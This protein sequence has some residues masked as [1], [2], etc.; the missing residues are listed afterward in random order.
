MARPT[1]T[2]KLG[3]DDKEQIKEKVDRILDR[4]RQVTVSLRV[5]A[6]LKTRLEARAAANHRNLSQEA[7]RA[8]ERSFDPVALFAD[9]LAA[10]D[11]LPPIIAGRGYLEQ[12]ARRV[13]GRYA[14]KPGILMMETLALIS[15]GPIEKRSDLPL[16]MRRTEFTLIREAVRAIEREC[17]IIEDEE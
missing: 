15:E 10:I 6:E 8:L 14:A 16:I 1:K 3:A 13:Y 2:P 9:T 5:P 17:E 7:E 12:M 11:I 4:G